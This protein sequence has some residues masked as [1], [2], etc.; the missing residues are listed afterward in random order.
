MVECGLPKPETWVRFPSS[1]PCEYGITAL[2]DA[3]NVGMR[4]RL[5]LLAPICI[6]KPL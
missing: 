2:S 3:S 6:V 4:V 1:A 5:P